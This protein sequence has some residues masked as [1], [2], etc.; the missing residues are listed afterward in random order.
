MAFEQL[1]RPPLVE[2]ILE[3]K[4]RMGAPAE[5]DQ[6]N[7]PLTV[8]SSLRPEL[9]VDPS[10]DLLLGKLFDRLSVTYPFHERLPSAT[11]PAEMVPFL[12]QHRFRTGE[13][14]WP[15]VQLGPGIIAL[16]D[17]ERYTWSDFSQ[18]ALRI[19][20]ILYDAH[21]RS[22][23]IVVESILLKYIDAELFDY[24]ANSV[25]DFLRQKLEVSFSLP[26]SLFQGTHTEAK[27]DGVN[28]QIVHP[29]FKPK[30]T[31]HLRFATGARY[32]EKAIVWETAV[33]SA[34]PDVPSMPQG[35][36][37]WL[38]ESHSLIHDWF[39]KLIEGELLRRYSQDDN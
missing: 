8:A 13:N 29:L 27:P 2:V 12:V 33:L 11:I 26:D 36:E 30:G 10:Y 31:A 16:N 15:L 14:T 37:K 28:F 6:P 18:R 38:E 19:L 1:K 39:F 3:L 4:W 25:L 21:P 17:T 34:G 5:A 23:D 24:A 22:S 32:G 9:A 20:N 7:A 35:A